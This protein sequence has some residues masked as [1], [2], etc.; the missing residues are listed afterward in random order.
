ML[1]S[2]GLSFGRKAL[3]ATSGSS[4]Y[5]QMISWTAEFNVGGA[6]LLALFT[7]GLDP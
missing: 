6:E 2:F 4:P 5:G 3:A 7:G 1:V